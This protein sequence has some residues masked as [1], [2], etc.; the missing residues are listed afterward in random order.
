MRY[1]SSGEGGPQDRHGLGPGL[2]AA[3]AEL[4][5][6]KTGKRSPQSHFPIQRAASVAAGMKL[7]KAGEVLR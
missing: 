7:M 1:L 2:T 5:P 3:V 6:E 4:S